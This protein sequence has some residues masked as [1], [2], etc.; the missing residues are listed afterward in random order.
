MPNKEDILREKTFKEEGM[1]TNRRVFYTLTSDDTL[2]SHRNS[3]LV[4]SLISL[5]Q[6]RGVISEMD[7]DELLFECIH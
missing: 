3:K 2:A 5:L 6:Q 7:I 4:A 1:E